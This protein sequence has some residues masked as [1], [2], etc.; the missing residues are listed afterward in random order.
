MSQ[1]SNYMTSCL[2]PTFNILY[3]LFNFASQNYKI[4]KLLV[5]KLLI[6]NLW[7]FIVFV[8]LDGIV[9]FLGDLQTKLQLFDVA[10]SKHKI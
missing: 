2:F 10:F 8:A 1:N 3:F 5:R 9:K 4:M 6:I 7:L